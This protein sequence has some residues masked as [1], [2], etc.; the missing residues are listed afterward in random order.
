MVERVGRFILAW[1]PPK[2]LIRA[3]ESIWSAF[4][5]YQGH[6]S[7]LVKIFGLA[8]VYQVLTFFVGYIV[9][10]S[11]NLEIEFFQ[12][13]WILAL[14]MIVQNIPISI[15]GLGVREGTFVFFFGLVGFSMEQALSYSLLGFALVAVISMVGGLIEGWSALR[16]RKFYELPNLEGQK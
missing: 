5:I 11:I 16:S 3:V 1:G 4:K 2:L 12:L 15:A 9:A 13:V 10:K 8:F 6:K 7:V 14:V